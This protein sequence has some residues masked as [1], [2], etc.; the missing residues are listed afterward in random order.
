VSDPKQE[1]PRASRSLLL[2]AAA[3]GGLA[4]FTAMAAIAVRGEPLA[5]DRE[6]LIALR[7]ADDP[8][9]PIGPEWLRVFAA[10]LT[11]LAGTP[12]LTIMTLSLAGYFALKRHWG[13]FFLLLAAVLGETALSNALKQF[14]NRARPDFIPHLVETASPSFPSGHATS[15][16]AVYLTLAALIGRETKERLVRNYVYFVA[17]LLALIVGASRVYL[18]VHYPT[19]VVGGLSF[20]AAWAA[21]VLIAARRL[22][23]GR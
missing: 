9:V 17:V 19:D 20:G 8:S 10:E 18:G 16:A 21:I 5:F 6:I 22:N 23:L 15:A 11:T 13:S 14:F 2:L 1:I 4:I 3:A 7:R 12:V